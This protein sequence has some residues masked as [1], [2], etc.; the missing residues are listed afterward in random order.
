MGVPDRAEPEV[1]QE[2]SALRATLDSFYPEFTQLFSRHLFG[3]L[4]RAAPVVI[5]SLESEPVQ[6][7]LRVAEGID[8]E[9]NTTLRSFAVR[10]GAALSPTPVE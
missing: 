8:A 1:E 2:F 6:A 5:S 7:Y 3:Y 4:G 10:I 9:V